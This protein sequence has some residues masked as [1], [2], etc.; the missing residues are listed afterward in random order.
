LAKSYIFKDL[1][2]VFTV[3]K[4]KMK[5]A[6]AVGKMVIIGVLIVVI[7]IA[8]V[9][10]YFLT[11]P[12]KLKET[13]IMGTTD[14]VESCLDTARAYDYFGLEI[15]QALGS[16]LVAY[17]PGATGVE[18]DFIPQ[19]ATS[20]SVS[21]DGLHWTFNLRQG[22]KY[23]DGT[24]FTADDVKYTFERGMGI[25]DPDGSF[26]GI[27]YSDF[28]QSITVVSQYVVEFNLKRPFGA[29]LSLI[30]YQGSYIVDPKYAPMHGTSWN[31]SD[32]VVYKDGDPRGSNPMGLG[33]YTLKSWTRVAGKD[34]EMSLQANPNYWDA[35]SGYPKAK[36]IVIKFY[37]DSAG[38]ALAITAGDVDVAYRQ[39]AST[40]ITSMKSNNDLKVWNG[41]GLIQYLCMQEKYAPFNNTMI[42]QAVAAAI[43]RTELVQTVFQGDAKE[44]YSMIP[45]GMLGHTDAFKTLGDANYSYT[46]QLLAPLGYNENNKLQFALWYE[47]SGHYPQ[48]AQQALVLKSSLE[49]SGVISVFLES[50][51][52]AAYRTARQQEIMHSY[53]LGWYPD[54]IDPDDYIY[55]FVQSSGGSWLHQNYANPMMDQLIEW[56]RGNTTEADRAS[57]Y[58]QINNLMVQDCPIIPIYQGYAY[59]VS[60]TNVQGVYLD[61]T[62]TW[63]LWLIYATE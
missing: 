55:P 33:P 27:G 37:A 16:P 49:A 45:I 25:A 60:R 54:Y 18:S 58:G 43:N 13:L 8:G 50:R 34:T 2:N 5:D 24:E 9:V 19:L 26:V 53:I 14:S 17:K 10:G 30:A 31:V 20:W 44:L 42:R 35:S 22:V 32:V 28:I 57:L 3:K 7:V 12:P 63:R 52:W 46:K 21:D 36:N 15:I 56:A 40:D 47:T 62:Q 39:L 1:I 4:L 61:A 48:S 23:D 51:D 41:P 59:A 6:K 38:L 11:I 29:F